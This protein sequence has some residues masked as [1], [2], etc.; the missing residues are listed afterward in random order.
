MGLVL[1][2]EREMALVRVLVAAKSSLVVV[3]VAMFWVQG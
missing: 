3:V 2:L 1:V